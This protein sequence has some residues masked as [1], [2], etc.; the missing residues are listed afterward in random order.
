MINRRDSFATSPSCVEREVEICK[1][2]RPERIMTCLMTMIRE[3][4]SFSVEGWV[5]AQKDDGFCKTVW[6]RLQEEEVT[7]YIWLNRRKEGNSHMKRKKEQNEEINPTT[8][9]LIHSLIFIKGRHPT[10]PLL[11][12]PPALTPPDALTIDQDVPPDVHRVCLVGH[13]LRC[14][15]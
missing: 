6:K 11:V 4:V 2:E 5:L 15:L 14:T 7:P 9:T 1:T 3:N 13:R 12:Q 8:L 10:I